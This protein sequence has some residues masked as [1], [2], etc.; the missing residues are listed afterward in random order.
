MKRFLRG[1]LL[2]MVGIAAGM[3]WMYCDLLLP[4]DLARGGASLVLA[5]RTAGIV[6]VLVMMFMPALPVQSLFPTRPAL[7]AA[8]VGW[9]PLAVGLSL[10][11]PIIDGMPNPHRVE[12]AMIEGCVDWMA[13]VVGAWGASRLRGKYA[14]QEQPVHDHH[15]AGQ[16]LGGQK[17]T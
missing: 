12:F 10:I 17:P 16:G 3:L 1:L 4:S 14:V 15:Q 6:T 11:Y 13:I 9:I 7:A 8:A 5:D 2:I